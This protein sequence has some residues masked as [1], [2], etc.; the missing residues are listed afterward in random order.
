MDAVCQ[1]NSFY[2]F[3]MIFLT[4][5]TAFK[6]SKMLKISGLK[7]VKRIK[8]KDLKVLFNQSDYLSHCNK[9]SD[10]LIVACFKR[11]GIEHADDN[12][13]RFGTRVCLKVMR[14]EFNGFF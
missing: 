7:R 5:L 4:F 11:V 3:Q 13:F 1:L 6:L 10:K 9:F 12:V 8:N 14:W 2:R